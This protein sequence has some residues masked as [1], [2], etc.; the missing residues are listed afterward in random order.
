[1]EIQDF[2]AYLVAII[3]IFLLIKK[4]YTKNLKN[5]QKDFAGKFYEFIGHRKKE[6]FTNVLD[7]SIWQLE[8]EVAI[9]VVEAKKYKLFPEEILR[10]MVPYTNVNMFVNINNSIA[11]KEIVELEEYFLTYLN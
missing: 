11:K 6:I 4:N 5:N 8:M 2:A 10:K 1:M 9:L 3:I 7:H